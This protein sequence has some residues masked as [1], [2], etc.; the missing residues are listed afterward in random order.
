MKNG[1][2]LWIENLAKRSLGRPGASA[3]SPHLVTQY[4]NAFLDDLTGLLLE[5]C[6][7]FNALVERENKAL[8]VR[9]LR[10][11]NPRPGIMIL[12]G[13]EK[14]LITLEGPYSIKAKLTQV[15]AF[16]EHHFDLMEFEPRQTRDGDL[17]WFTTEG[18]AVSPEL[19]AKTIAGPFL[20]HGGKAFESQLSSENG[21]REDD[22]RA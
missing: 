9:A 16:Q 1:D 2:L 3:A 11:G 5:F 10:L 15:K 8:Q 19:V 17:G 21:K 20:V 7:R 6:E 18:R 12:R 14:L 13:K 4:V 22:A